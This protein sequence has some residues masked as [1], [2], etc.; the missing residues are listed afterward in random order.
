[1]R[2]KDH[3]DRWFTTI[4][5]PS[6]VLF[7]NPQNPCFHSDP[8]FPDCPARDSI[9]LHGVVL[10]HQGSIE[11]LVERVENWRDSVTE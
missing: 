3:A 2:D 9:T 8:S 11:G 1:M 6:R 10:F 4:W 5:Q 7:C